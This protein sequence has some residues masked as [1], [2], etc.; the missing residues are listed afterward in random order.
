MI[1]AFREE[2]TPAALVGAPS[3]PES[4]HEGLPGGG[5]ADQCEIGR[6]VLTRSN[7]RVTQ[8]TWLSVSVLDNLIVGRSVR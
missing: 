3:R 1:C 6:F 2:A 4:V 7:V 5:P 8:T